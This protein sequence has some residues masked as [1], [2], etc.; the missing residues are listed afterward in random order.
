MTKREPVVIGAFYDR[1]PE[2]CKK[3]IDRYVKDYEPPTDL[4]S[5]MGGVVPHAGWV[6]SGATAAKVFLTVAKLA[7]PETVVIFG[8][9]HRGG[10]REVAAFG[11]GSWVTPFGEVEVDEEL[12]KKIVDESEGTV[13]E[14]P[15]AHLGEHSIE[16]QLPFIN[17]LYPKAR[18]L[19][20]AA[21]LTADVVAGGKH[22]GRVIKQ[23]DKR[24]AVIASTDLT[25]YGINYMTVSHGPLP[26]AMP[27]IRENDARLIRLV[28]KMQAEKI[29]PEVMHNENACGAGALAAA[30]AAA[31]E[32]GSKQARLLEYTTSADVMEDYSSG[33]A[34][35]YA[36]MVFC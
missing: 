9:V 22:I 13:T 26:E 35:G 10:V 23:S 28:E 33:S 31:S 30:V 16:V 15:I 18:I 7:D 14:D 32:M 5:V 6:Y 8:A 12:G 27:W 1:T 36:A 17:H 24:V 3:S 2:G 20:I 34:V 25:H 4:K 21:P 11:P 19:P 29:V